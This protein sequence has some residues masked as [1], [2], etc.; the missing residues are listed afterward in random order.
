MPPIWRISSSLF[1]ATCESSDARALLKARSSDFLF[2]SGIKGL[3]AVD[4][5][6]PCKLGQIYWFCNMILDCRR[7]DS[8]RE[9]IVCAGSDAEKITAC[10]LMV[11]SFLILCER[12]PA[13]V[14][15]AAFR[16]I[17]DRFA[18]Y[19]DSSRHPAADLSV[20]ECW[21]ALYAVLS[22]GWLDFMELDVDIDKCI[23]MQ[24]YFDR[25]SGKKSRLVNPDTRDRRSTCIMTVP[26]TVS[27][28]SS[29][30]QG[31]LAPRHHRNPK[32]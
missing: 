13:A 6:H 21:D 24:V 32:R 18:G 11:G 26:S 16:P 10:A 23:D 15:G 9:I 20:F 19:N 7:E 22:L 17:A 29:C 4:G 28:T 2:I 8:E 31:T 1:L 30:R 27:S 12:I 14:V 25:D 3:D 5:H